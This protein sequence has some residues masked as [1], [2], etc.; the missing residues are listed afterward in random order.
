[1]RQRMWRSKAMGQWRQQD[2]DKEGGGRG[3][4]YE[5]VPQENKMMLEEQD[6]ETVERKQENRNKVE[7]EGINE[8]V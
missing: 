5:D 8:D 7:E 1:M 6:V 3:K 2:E 4:E